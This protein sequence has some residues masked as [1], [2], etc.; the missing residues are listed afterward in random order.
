MAAF[1]H[2]LADPA[3]RFLW[4]GNPDEVQFDAVAALLRLLEQ[5]HVG[6]AA[7]SGFERECLAARDLF[8]Q[9]AEQESSSFEGYD[10]RSKRR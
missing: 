9:L 6:A 5:I 3:N 10:L 8:T 2:S 7:E 4:I 1:L